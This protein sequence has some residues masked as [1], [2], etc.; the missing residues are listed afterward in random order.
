MAGFY[1]TKWYALAHAGC[2]AIQNNDAN[3]I[4]YMTS[5]KVFTHSIMAPHVSNTDASDTGVELL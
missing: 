3:N 2:H 4:S 1:Y 5:Y